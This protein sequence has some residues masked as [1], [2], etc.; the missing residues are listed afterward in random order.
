MSDNMPPTPAPSQAEQPVGTISGGLLNYVVIS[1][2]FLIV[3]VVIGV[4]VGA[5]NATL[6]EMTVERAVRAALADMNLGAAQDDRFEL[7]GDSP[8]LGATDAPVVIVEFS[9]F[10]C[11]YCGR[12]YENTLNPLLENYGD[13]IRYVYRHFAALGPES[14]TAAIASECA[15]EQGKFW[16]FHDKFFTNQPMLGRDF[17]LATASEFDLDV[18]Q[19]TA[20]L[21]ESRYLTQVSNDGIDGQLNGVNGTPGFFINGHFV[22]GAQPY[23]IFERIVLRELQKVGIDPS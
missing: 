8:Y 11:P 20:C 15:N 18:E 17:Y 5:N 7:V 22:R 6:D 10:R 1:L 2:T 16:E 9:D 12:H 23:E 3:G 19:F 4:T 13:H 21:D 14:V